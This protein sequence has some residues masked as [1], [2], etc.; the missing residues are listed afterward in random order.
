MK[1]DYELKIFTSYNFSFYLINLIGGPIN[2]PI[3]AKKIGTSNVF[4]SIS[5]NKNIL[6]GNY[7][8]DIMGILIKLYNYFKNITV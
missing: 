1:E 5:K 7:C 8:S 2:S 4:K 6:K 3:T